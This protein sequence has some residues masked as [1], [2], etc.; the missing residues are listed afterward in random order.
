MTYQEIIDMYEK[1]ENQ[2]LFYKNEIIKTCKAII[3]EQDNDT[4]RNTSN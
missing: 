4:R 3:K 2:F 1:E